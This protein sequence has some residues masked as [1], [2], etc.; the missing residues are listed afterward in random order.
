MQDEV[1]L[2]AGA[3]VAV[4]TIFAMVDRA[5]G[6]MVEACVDDSSFFTLAS[7]PRVISKLPINNSDQSDLLGFKC[8]KSQIMDHCL[9]FPRGVVF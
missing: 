8:T 3:T 5:V 7:H 4:S 9:P 2:T 1:R 6:V